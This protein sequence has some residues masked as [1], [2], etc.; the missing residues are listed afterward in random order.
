MGSKVSKQIERRK[1]AST[2]KKTMVDLCESC[3]VEF[4]GS[5]YR[6]EDRKNWMKGLNPEKVH[7]DK[8]V[9]PGTHDSATNKIGIPC[10]SRPFAQCQ[11]LS[12][13][14][15]LVQGTRVLD[16]R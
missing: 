15:Q 10:L 16:I 2:Q 4:P 3:G 14:H 8:I 6:P 13:Y 9:W 5:D 7:L 1:A 12:I 11:C